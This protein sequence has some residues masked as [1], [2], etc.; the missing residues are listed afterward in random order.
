MSSLGL[1]PE[2]GFAQNQ[3]DFSDDWGLAFPD[4]LIDWPDF[5]T[6]LAEWS[7]IGARNY[8]NDLLVSLARVKI[9]GLD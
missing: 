6:D 1:L 3:S 4:A 5:E 2:G 8:V 7:G 9:K